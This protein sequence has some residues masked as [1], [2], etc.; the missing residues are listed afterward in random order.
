MTDWKAELRAAAGWA[1]YL[2]GLVICATLLGFCGWAALR[3][4]R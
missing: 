1:W 3:A 4:L 2:I